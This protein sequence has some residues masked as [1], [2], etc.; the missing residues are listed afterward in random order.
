[1]F[2]VRLK[3]NYLGYPCYLSVFSMDEVLKTTD[4]VTCPYDPNHRMKYSKFHNHFV[5]CKEAHPDDPREQ[6]PYYASEL[7][8]P[9]K[10]KDHLI[11]CKYKALYTDLF[12]DSSGLPVYDAPCHF[13]FDEESGDD[14]DD[15]V[16]TVITMRDKD[17][18]SSLFSGTTRRSYRPA[19]TVSQPIGKLRSN[20]YIGA[21]SKV[22]SYAFRYIEDDND[23]SGSLGE[24]QVTDDSGN[25]S[26]QSSNGDSPTFN[27]TTSFTSSSGTG[28]LQNS[29]SGDGSFSSPSV[30]SSPIKPFDRK[31]G[32]GRGK[33]IQK[34]LSS[35]T[36]SL[37]SQGGGSGRGAWFRSRMNLD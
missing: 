12:Y 25:F 22:E 19:S 4:W 9:D 1:M 35:S 16:E 20:N 17:D 2:P 26:W 32:L 36:A 29:H 24:L 27:Q 11:T 5:K 10:M 30:S 7:I 28:S 15:D 31:V 34:L 13:N 3:L 23:L 37:D 21:K 18:R 6:C 8:H 14:T 33:V